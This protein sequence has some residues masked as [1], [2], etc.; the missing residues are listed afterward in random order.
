MYGVLYT[1]YGYSLSEGENVNKLKALYLTIV[2]LFGELKTKFNE[3][4]KL[5]ETLALWRANQ[6]G[7]MTYDVIDIMVVLIMIGS[8]GTS[9]WNFGATNF[10]QADASVQVM[11]GTVVPMLAGV[12][13]V[14]V[15][16]KRRRG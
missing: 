12:A 8:M 1:L 16:L 9:A 14:F 3:Q 5:V 4:V 6:R 11:I 2:A 7:S 13:C 15:L 10:S